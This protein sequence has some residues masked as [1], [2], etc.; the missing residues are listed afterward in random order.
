[1]PIFRTP[2]FSPLNVSGC[3]LWFDAEDTKT[4]TFSGNTVTSWRSKGSSAVST[5]VVSG[6]FT[7]P[8]Y[9]SYNSLPALGFN[10]T[11]TYVQTGNVSVPGTGMTW[12]TCSV[13][14]T[15]VTAS[16]PVDSS[17]V[18]ATEAPSERAIRYILTGG[19]TYYTINSN[20]TNTATVLR[21]NINENANGIRGFMDTAAYFTGFTNGTQTVSNTTAVNYIATNNQPFL[22]GKWASGFLNGYIYESLVYNRVLTLAEY[23]QVEGYLAQKWG[24]TGSL[25]AGHPGLGRTLSKIIKVSRL[26]YYRFF[27]PQTISSLALWLDAADSSTVTGTSPITA[28]TDKSSAGR[29]VTITSGP[30]YGTTIRNGLKTMY[31]NNNVISS[32]IASAVGTGDFTLIAVWYQSSAGTNTVL[33]LGTVAS[34]SQSLGY[35][36]DKYNF[37]QFGSLESAYTTGPGWVVQVGTRISSIKRVYITGTIGS[38]PASDSFNVTDTTVTIGKGDNFPITGE[39]AEIMVYTGTMSDTDRQLLEGYLAQKWGLTGSLVAGHPSLTLPVG[40]PATGVG[41]QT[42]SYLPRPPSFSPLSISG[43]QVWLDANDTGTITQDATSNISQ[44]SDKS[45]NG[46]NAVTNSF[47]GWAEPTYVG[48]GAIKYV[49]LEPGQA[50]YIPNFPYTTSWSV[51]SCMCNVSL[52]GR[53]YISPY[54]DL[55]IVL[56]GMGHGGNK[57]FPDRLGGGNDVEG[58]HIEYTSAENTDGTGAYTYYRDGSLIDS[59][60]ATYNTPSATVRMGI[61]ANGASGFDIDGIYYPFEILMYNQY[62]G[63]TDRQKIEGYLAWK[64]G[65][66][67]SLPIGHPYK[68]A[69]P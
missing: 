53:W 29:T 64:W 56:M 61:G 24:F 43:L 59:N 16:T 32:S 60:N 33:S 12:I 20:L 3:V 44:W 52:G 55:E 9:T 68:S 28:W 23:Q 22:M 48:T 15:P 10:G 50:L 69:A 46:L 25:P 19:N 34:S 38:V 8:T 45:S 65:L 11:S 1:M 13:N 42:I 17:V 2:Y 27:N 66:Q 5:N 54:S 40:A 58:G 21:G 67:A 37:Y 39:I 57:I 31:F 36:G 18:L 49:S 4:M 47:V 6:G 7:N 62:L 63:D 30:T 51:F 35:S 41:K 26:P 14:L